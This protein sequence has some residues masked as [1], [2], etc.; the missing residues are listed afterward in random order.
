MKNSSRYCIYDFPQI[1]EK[2]GYSN[3]GLNHLK[4]VFANIQGKGFHV[5]NG[6][7]IGAAGVY[8][9]FKQNPKS[10]RFRLITND[11]RDEIILNH[12]DNEFATVNG[13]TPDSLII[14]PHEFFTTPIAKR[15]TKRMMVLKK[16]VIYL[17]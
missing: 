12:P 16:F 11:V 6:I 4:E 2:E 13:C 8:P 17:H 15:T 10:L 9:F 3:K 7:I 14:G 1:G 5:E